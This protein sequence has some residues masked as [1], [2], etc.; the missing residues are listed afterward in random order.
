M[1]KNTR[2]WEIKFSTINQRIKRGTRKK[3]YFEIKRYRKL[4]LIDL[5]PTIQQHEWS[6][7]K[8]SQNKKVT[9]LFVEQEKKCE[10]FKLEEKKYPNLLNTLS[11]QDQTNTEWTVCEWWNKKPTQ[12]TKNN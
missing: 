5:W 4:E 12:L 7:L 3:K 11:M 8:W 9:I 10:W 1:K 6:E 2:K